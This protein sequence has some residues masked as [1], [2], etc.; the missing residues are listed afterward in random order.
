MK[1]TLYILIVLMLVNLTQIATT[2]TILFI[3]DEERAKELKLELS[4]S[5][6]DTNKVMLL[7]ELTFVLHNSAPNESIEYGLKGIEL[8]KKINWRKGEAYCYNSLSICY[9]SGIDNH[10][11]AI[12]FDKKA[13]SIYNEL[14]D[15]ASIGYH[16]MR[17]GISNYQ[18]Y[19]KS[20]TSSFEESKK[21][22]LK[23]EEL[24]K[25][26]NAYKDLKKLYFTQS[27]IYNEIGEYKKALE[28]NKKETFALESYLQ[29]KHGEEITS[30]ENKM[31]NLLDS[32][33]ELIILAEQKKKEQLILYFS[34]CILAL[35][36]LVVFLT[37]KLK[38][39][40]KKL[41]EESINGNLINQEGNPFEE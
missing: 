2:K 6:E 41:M 11:K 13:I 24:F 27:Y 37:Y 36:L 32:E 10:L 1:S 4:I 33:K 3:S 35:L 8:A 15:T 21:Y 7:Q 39:L 40:S 23:A 31:F 26:I 20:N 29:Q 30:I 22:F 25:R 19:K 34:I 17:I 14:G 16:Y 9:A 5:K 28:F 18:L 38:Q 12:E